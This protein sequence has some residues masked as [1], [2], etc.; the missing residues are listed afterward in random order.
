MSKLIAFFAKCLFFVVLLD[1]PV[2]A[3]QF[4]CV[5]NS[6]VID[7][8]GAQ[9]SCLALTISNL[10]SK[11]LQSVTGVHQAGKVNDD[12]GYL[13]IVNAKSLTYF[14]TGIAEFFK[15]LEALAISGASLTSISAEDLRPFPG[16]LSFQLLG[17]QLTSV[18]GDLFKYTPKLQYLDLSN[19]KIAHIGQDLLTNLKLTQLR[20]K[21]NA[22]V[23]Q[24]ANTTASVLLLAS[25]L[26][27]LCPSLD[28]PTTTTKATATTEITASDSTTITNDQ[29]SCN[30]EIQRQNRRIDQLLEENLEQNRKIDQLQ[31]TNKVSAQETAAFKKK[32]LA[33]VNQF[34]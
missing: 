5:F 9:Y 17:N 1:C 18:D 33:F 24:N 16:L 3:I 25:Q 26:P 21:G 30:K 15:N 34:L 23:D 8:A 2:K 14:P 7:V 19:N 10:D 4:D 20:L 31:Q 6:Y 11:S 28:V 29:C 13:F 22:C 32:L 27:V 12:V